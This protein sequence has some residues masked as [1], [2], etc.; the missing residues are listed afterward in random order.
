MVDFEDRDVVEEAMDLS[1]AMEEAAE[2]AAKRARPVRHVSHGGSDAG[3]V[4]IKH[5]QNLK[6]L[7]Y[8]ETLTGTATPTTLAA[9]AQM[10]IDLRAGPV[11]SGNLG[12]LAAETAMRTLFEARPCWNL[13]GHDL[14]GTIEKKAVSLRAMLRDVQQQMHKSKTGRNPPPWV[15]PFLADLPSAAAVPED[16]PSA[17]AVPEISTARSSKGPLTST[18]ASTLP[19]RFAWD[20]DMQTAYRKIKPED[21]P[22]YCDSVEGQSK[23][24][25]PAVAIWP[26]GVRW[27]IPTMTTAQRMQQQRETR[28][29]EADKHIV[30]GPWH[31][32]NRGDIEAEYAVRCEKPHHLASCSTEGW[33]QAEGASGLSASLGQLV[34][35]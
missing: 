35:S 13:C 27:E 25:D 5:I 33:W 10:L 16:L 9:K 15:L 3:A 4:L 22:E 29:I 7:T 12:K 1:P 32:F 30:E 20:D 8:R 31:V 6:D 21:K 26:D 24:S 17:A 14:Q 23:A 11:T 18:E 34:H 28:T 2:P 19:W